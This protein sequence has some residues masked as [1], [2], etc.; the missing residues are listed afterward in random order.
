MKAVV[1][2]EYGPLEQLRIQSVPEPELRNGCV[3]IGVKVAAINPPDVLMPQGKYHVKPPFPFVLGI[4]A[5]GVVLETAPDVSAL[6]VGDRVMTYAGDSCFAEQIVVPATRV[7]KVPDGMSD[8]TAA[9]FSVVYGTAHHALVDAGALQK[10]ETLVV[11][12]ASG[13]IGL[14]SIQIGKALGARVIAVASTAEKL[15]KCK[16][17]GAD[18]LIQGDE[19]LRDRIKELTGGKGAEVIMDIVGGDATD[20]AIRAIA[21]YGRYLIAG[22]ASGIVPN[23]KANLIFLKQ[24]RVIGASFRILLERSPESAAANIRHLC[25]LWEHGLLKPEVTARYPFEQV[26]DALKHV[27]ERKV[28]GKAVLHVQSA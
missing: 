7:F 1:V 11:L 17:H 14:C 15:A 13:G 10:G 3:R 8:E 25:D 2:S 23:I 24:A 18:E 16:E 27:G 19:S 4:E 12:G 28:V 20:S 6:R 9:G 5:A 22:Y 26:V 21:P